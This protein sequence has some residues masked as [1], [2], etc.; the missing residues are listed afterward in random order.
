MKDD[1][2]NLDAITE[3]DH[4]MEHLPLEV[5]LEEKNEPYPNNFSAPEDQQD[6]LTKKRKKT[7]RLRDLLKISR[8]TTHEVGPDCLCKTLECFKTVP[9]A[10]RERILR[11]FNDLA[12][13]YKQD[14]Y[15]SSL[16]TA[17]PVKRRQP[18]KG[19]KEARPNTAS[20][21]YRVRTVLDYDVPVCLK[22]FISIHG[23][24]ERR[25]KFLRESLRNTGLPPVDRRGKHSKQKHR[26][27]TET[28]DKVKNFIRSHRGHKSNYSL[29]DTKKLYL[30][31]QLNITKLH[32]MYCDQ[33]PNN[34]LSYESFRNILQSD[35]SIYLLVTQEK[36]GNECDAL[37]AAIPLLTEK[38]TTETNGKNLEKDK[39]KI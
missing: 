13:R 30:S 14:V 20:Y 19:A 26:L 15:L 5:I 23:I 38:T 10:E 2:N 18:R 8:L 6:I 31:E 27:S 3:I 16:I 24:T 4:K 12:D 39:I 28:V 9:E 1:E 33:F 29:S 22:A 25:I 21:T 7:G 35:P 11:E 34:K 17:L 36:N 32:K 37:N